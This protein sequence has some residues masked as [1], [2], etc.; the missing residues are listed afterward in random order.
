[1]RIVEVKFLNKVDEGYG[2]SYFYKDKLSKSLKQFDTVLVPTRYGVSIA[3]VTAL[4]KDTDDIMSK[5]TRSSMQFVLEKIKSKVINE[6]L[7]EEKAKQLKQQLE[8]EIKK[9]DAVEK[10]RMY[11]ESSPEVAALLA[12]L[13]ELNG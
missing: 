4:H 10:Y 8:N 12:Q 2:D 7:K 3:V 11:A 9:M 1:M 13:E 5:F 6:L